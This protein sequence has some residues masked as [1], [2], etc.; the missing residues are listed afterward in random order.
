MGRPF[1]CPFCNSTSSASKG[2]RRTK[3]MG[4]RHI[5]RCQGC[6]RRFTPKHQKSEPVSAA[7]V[8]VATQSVQPQPVAPSEPTKPSEVPG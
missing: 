4:V 5:R 8:S 6:K 3:T 7:P 2:V 1:V